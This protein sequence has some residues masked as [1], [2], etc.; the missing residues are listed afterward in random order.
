MCTVVIEVPVDRM[1]PTR[2]LAVRDEDPA[3]VWDPPGRWWPE[4]P[5]TIGVRD[6]RA[7]G[8]WLAY[9]GQPGR[10]AVLLNRAAD[11]AEPASGFTSRGGLVLAATAGARVPDPPTT[12]AFTLIEVR[13]G[14]AESVS[15]DGSELRRAALTPGIHM[16]AHHEVDDP[17]SARIARWLPEF[18]ALGGSPAATWRTAW[19][20]LLAASTELGRED[21]RAIV[22]DNTVHGY[23]T[24]SLLACI[25]EIGED[26]VALDWAAFDQPGH[27]SD[28][29]FRRADLGGTLTR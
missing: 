1:T 11:V 10:L 18:Q 15:W 2:L 29:E 9:A 3:R 4:H 28:P 21:D 27:W 20:E 16:I 14:T 7:N 19:L 26:G 17:S 6:R 13:G 25:A 23:P 8:A 24:L 5:D 12:P 22:R